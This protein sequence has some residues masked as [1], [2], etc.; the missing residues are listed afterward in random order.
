VSLTNQVN[1]SGF[2][3]QLAVSNL[4]N[5][6]QT[7]WRVLYEEHAWTHES[8]DGYIDLVLE[9]KYR[10]WLM[11]IEC[12]RVIDSSWVFLKDMSKPQTR[13]HA[14]LW[15]TKIA[16][17]NSG[18]KQIGWV[19]IPMD[20]PCDESSIC[21]V[22]GQN[23]KDRPMLERTASILVRSTEALAQ[24]EGNTVSHQYSGLRIYQNVIVTTAKLNVAEV[25]S[26]DIN[27]ATGEIDEKTTFREVPYV[28]FRKQIGGTLPSIKAA[29]HSRDLRQI[30]LEKESTVFVVN[31]AALL[32]FLLACELPE[33]LERYV[34]SV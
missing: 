28:R 19:D 2:P 7:G 30:T 10:T 26:E 3:L 5:K 17:V 25:V 12:K 32:D 34:T 6:S 14:K 24:E 8:G 21:I 4:V 9:D 15:V 29:V 20:P 27:L 22:P 11:N 16:D 23:A 1:R 31:A 33:R 18:L 13:A